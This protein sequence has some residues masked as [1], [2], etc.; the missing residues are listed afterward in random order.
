[1]RMSFPKRSE[2][3]FGVDAVTAPGKDIL[4]GDGDAEENSVCDLQHHEPRASPGKMDGSSFR[5]LLK[6]GKKADAFKLLHFICGG[7]QSR[8]NATYCTFPGRD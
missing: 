5:V 6:N 7:N 1:M 3:E 2:S 4:P 8:I